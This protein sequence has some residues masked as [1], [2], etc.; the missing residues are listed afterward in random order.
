MALKSAFLKFCL[1][2]IIKARLKIILMGFSKIRLR[3]S[4]MFNIKKADKT[5]LIEIYIIYEK[6]VTQLS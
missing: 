3:Y 5:F 2:G 6:D 1:C 4:N